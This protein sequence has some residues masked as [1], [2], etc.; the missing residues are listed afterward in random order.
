MK[1][2]IL[3]RN[4]RSYS[5]AR[6]VQAATYRGHK[7]KVLDTLRFAIS[8]E[9]RFPDLFYGGKP[10]AHY[11]AV[12]PRIGSSI[13]YH[14]TAVVRQFEEM[15]VFSCNSALGITYSRDKL[16]CLQI[17]SRH[18]VGLPDSAFVRSKVDVLPAIERLGG[19]PVIVKLLEGTQGIG[20]ILAET[21][22]MAE[23]IIETLQSAKQNVLIQKFVSESKGKDIRAFVVGDRVV[24]AMRRTAKGQ[25]FRSNV[26]R[27]G[28]TEAIVLDR[29]FEE[30]AVRAA[31]I[32]A[33][34]VA[35]VDMLE[36]KDGPQIMEVNS[37]PG[38]EGI[39]NCTKADVAG[40]I[41]EFI[42]DR[43]GFP[44]MDLRQ[45]LT[46]SRGYGAAEIIVASKTPLVG[47]KLSDC[48]LKEMDIRVLTLARGDL[49]IPNPSDSRKLRVGDKLLCFGPLKEMKAF[50]PVRKRRRVRKLTKKVIQEATD[51]ADQA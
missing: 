47:A 45:R 37:S 14:G 5:T 42:E 13:T 24:A 27:G 7:A 9:P 49:I 19:A 30:T 2:A 51:I 8:L 21:R 33:L 29:V 25:E 31:Q 17:L 39:E 11:D 26:H 23:A 43:V 20:V 38:L 12:I 10:V 18:D 4:K 41:I 36:S 6:L 40:S 28:T 34:R 35:G 44:E 1:L 46:V 32:V 50:I 16:R 48:G 22:Q 3:S 15:G